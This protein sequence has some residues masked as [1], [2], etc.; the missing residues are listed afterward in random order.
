LL[1]A[2]GA[3]VCV[4]DRDD[5][6]GTQVARELA[7]KG[8]SASFM[9]VDLADP[10]AISPAIAKVVDRFD[11]VDILVNS[12]GIRSADSSKGRAGIFEIDREHWD[13]V[14]AINL[15]AP[16][17]MIQAV[18][19]YMIARSA[20]GRIVNV[21]SSA[22]FQ[23][24]Y[25][26]IHYAASKAGLSSLTR[27]AAADLG[28]HGITVNAVAPGPVRTPMLQIDRDDEALRRAVI[29]GPMAN[30]LGALAEPEDIAEVICFLCLPASRHMT[31]QTVHTSAGLIV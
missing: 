21:S 28:P 4:F 23:A 22:A 2:H 17:L 3:A 14:Q 5:V 8:A 31:G 7:D 12:A 6:G 9:Q 20:G 11:H 16:F 13:L 25:C 29:E 27:T 10:T 30:L 24:K 18:S 19:A 15:R 26:S 1:A